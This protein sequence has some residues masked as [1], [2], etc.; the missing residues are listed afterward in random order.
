MKYIKYLIIMILIIPALS[1]AQLKKDVAT[2]NISNTLSTAAFN[3][4]MFGFL[5]PS[6]FH[7][8]HGFSMSYMTMGGVGMML[9]SYT[10]TINYRF[11]EK[12]FLTTKLGIMN[13]P[14]NSLPGNSPW[15]DV[16]F[17]GG[18]ELKYLPSEDSAII[19]RF[20]STPMMYPGNRYYYRSPLGLFN[21]DW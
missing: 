3:N 5:D 8:S 6:K 14:Y 15:N 11:S 20:E 18:A 7:M 17:F 16:Q 19:F 2:T 9:N 21:R 12:L 13:S 10:N 1:F 4:S